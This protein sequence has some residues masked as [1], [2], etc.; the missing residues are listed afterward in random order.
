MKLGHHWLRGLP[1]SA[2]A[3]LSLLASG[4][5]P[6]RAQSDFP[7]RPIHVVVGFAAGGGNDIFARLVSAKVSEILHQS[8]V[9]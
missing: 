8:V 5:A 1:L 6:A 9:V 2:L 3:D 4:P 7:N